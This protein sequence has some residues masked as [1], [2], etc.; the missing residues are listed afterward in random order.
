MTNDLG[1]PAFGKGLFGWV[2]FIALAVMLFML[3]NK[4]NAQYSPVAISDV[5]EQ[6]KDGHVSY[7]TIDGDKLVGEFR[8]PLPLGEQRE[9]IVRFQSPLPTGAGGE[10]ATLQ[11]LTDNAQGAKVYVENGPNLLMNILVPL[12]PWL[13]IFGFIWFFVFRQ[14]RNVRKPGTPVEPMRVVVVN[15]PGEIP[16]AAE[17]EPAPPP[18]T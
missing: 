8:S 15:M 4:T 17:V 13:L 7:V 10:F 11:Y 18:A 6:L 14:L 2:L 3:L 16:L 12:I 9:R 5:L 1:R